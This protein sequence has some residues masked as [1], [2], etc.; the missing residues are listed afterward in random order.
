MKMDSRTDASVAS[1]SVERLEKRASEIVS[2]IQ[3][4][5]EILRNV[6]EFSALEPV[7]LWTAVKKSSQR[8]SDLTSSNQNGNVKK[9]NDLMGQTDLF[10]ILEEQGVLSAVNDLIGNKRWAENSSSRARLTCEILIPLAKALA[11]CYQALDQVPATEHPPKPFSQ[12]KIGTRKHQQQSPPPPP[13]AGMLSL[14]NYT[15]IGAFLEFWVCTS[16]LPFLE[17]YILFSVEDRARY[18]LPKSLAGRISK[19]ALL[20]GSHQLK[21]T[22]NGEHTAQPIVHELRAS[23]ATLG[24]LL[25]LDRFRPML[26]P[27]HLAD[28]YAAIFQSEIYSSRTP[29]SSQNKETDKSVPDVSKDFNEILSLLLPSATQKTKTSPK[30]GSGDSRIPQLAPVDPGLQAQ[31]LQ[32]LLLQGTKSPPWLRRRV[33]DRL[34]AIACQNLPVILQVFVHAAPP[35]DKTAASMRLA[36]TL[37]SPSLTSSTKQDRSVFFGSLCRELIKVLDNIVD[38]DLREDIKTGAGN[39][40]SKQAL[41]VHTV[42][43]VLNQFSENEMQKFVLHRLAEGFVDGGGPCGSTAIH[44]SVKRLMILLTAIPP[45]L[46]ASKIPQLFVV[47]LREVGTFKA[48]ITDVEGTKTTILGTMIRLVS[49]QRGPLKSDLHDDTVYALRML[50]HVMTKSKTSFTL[51]EMS[52]D[53]ASTKSSPQ[54]TVTQPADGVET[55]AMALV[56]SLAPSA[57]DLRGNCYR[58]KSRAPQDAALPTHSHLD[59]VSIVCQSKLN[60]EM[61]DCLPMIQQRVSMLMEH[62]IEP[63][64]CASDG[65]QAGEGGSEI[66]RGGDDALVSTLFHL[67]L[68]LYF[69]AVS[70]QRNKASQ[71]PAIFKNDN[72]YFYVVAMYVLPLLCEKCPPESLLVTHRNDGT[73][74]LKMMHLIFACAASYM[75]PEVTQQDPWHGEKPTIE[76]DKSSDPSFKPSTAYS[77]ERSDRFLSQMLLRAKLG[78]GADSTTVHTCDNESQGIDFSDIE[79]LL[80]I[81]S[82]LLSLLIAILEL[83]TESRRR[84]EEESILDSFS[85]LLRPLAEV[86]DGYWIQ[87]KLNHR[88]YSQEF[89]LSVSASCAELAEMAAHAMVLLGARKAPAS[90]PS[91]YNVYSSSTEMEKNLEDTIHETFTQA[92]KD[93]K[94][95][96]APIRAKSIVSLQRMLRSSLYEDITSEEVIR[97]TRRRLIVDMDEAR[98]SNL[99]LADKTLNRVLRLSVLALADSES[100]VYLA[101]VHCLAIASDVNSSAVFPMVA[102][103]LSTGVLTTVES[104]NGAETDTT[105]TSEQRV[106]LAEALIFSIRRRARI[107]D[108]VVPLMDIMIF[109]DNKVSVDDG[110]SQTANTATSQR[111]QKETLDYFLLR[112][113]MGSADDD[114][115]EI[116][117]FEKQKI[118]YNTG[119]PLFGPEEMDVVRAARLTVISELLCALHPSVLSKY[120]TVIIRIVTNS[121]RLE[122]SRPVRRAAASLA[123]DIYYALL[124]EQNGLFEA[125]ADVSGAAN[126]KTDLKLATAMVSSKNDELLS[127]TLQRCLSADDLGDVDGYRLF[128]AATAARCEE[129]LDARKEAVGGGVLAVAEVLAAGRENKCRV[130]SARVLRDLLRRGPNRDDDH[131]N[132]IR[133]LRGLGIHPD[134]LEFY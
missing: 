43:A 79:M 28:L 67:V 30:A 87:K 7:T 115:D 118:R 127:I 123:R 39:L 10:A 80:S 20:W 69:T 16:I 41:D 107:D 128:D 129:A 119:G 37:V 65:I 110:S 64:F 82:L 34:T 48:G 58:L 57:W 93:L 46:N 52:K 78:G 109:G 66:A 22:G 131:D 36:H 85:T 6:K 47:P 68:I 73:G 132:A 99:S 92:E 96:Q 60:D 125:F 103:A 62:I 101:A 51:S 42:W 95:T 1:L 40:T 112:T 45:S 56:Y 5:V 77:F 14:Q 63:L 19:A 121:L 133:A 59:H 25:L 86:S 27:R 84:E 4:C 117:R 91:Q 120:C 35:K 18:F 122:V 97:P 94:S 76:R 12:G 134:S 61:H 17:P 2:W 71:L 100:Y 53:S 114:E 104:A 9:I 55:I 72:Q 116:E 50:I 32:T 24:R 130:P 81:T 89:F 54:N 98:V 88:N 29:Q 70:S 3:K 90:G 33:S 105:L 124:R 15:D 44:R 21:E 108:Y 26:L 8:G 23:V 49:M 111:I 83:G 75:K 13:P 106:K 31:A 102:V 11:D 126:V 113:E 38:D 74:I